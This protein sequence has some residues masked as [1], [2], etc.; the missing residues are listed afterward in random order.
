LSP[1]DGKGQSSLQPMTH[2]LQILPER[3]PWLFNPEV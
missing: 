1:A 3:N 2:W